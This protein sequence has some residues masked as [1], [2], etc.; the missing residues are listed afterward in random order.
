MGRLGERV[1]SLEALA[2]SAVVMTIVTAATLLAVRQSVDGYADAARQPAWLWLGGAMGA[3]IVFTVTIAGPRIG[4]LATSSLIIAGQFAAGTA[5]D[6]YGW[7]G[8]ARV[9]VS[10]QR[11][12]GLVLLAAGAALA[13]RR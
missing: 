11:V 3:I 8:V 6:R 12:V 2:F 13:L 1:G 9:E 7:F 4:I 5:I 10:W